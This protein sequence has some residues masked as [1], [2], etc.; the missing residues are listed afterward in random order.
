MKTRSDVVGQAK[1]R[2][3]L[4]SG[5]NE[6]M[7]KHRGIQLFGVYAYITELSPIADRQFLYQFGL[8]HS[9]EHEPIQ[10]MIGETS[11]DVWIK[12]VRIARLRCP[13]S[14]EVV[15]D[16]SRYFISQAGCFTLFSIR[17]ACKEAAPGEKTKHCKPTR[18]HGSPQ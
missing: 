5:E 7:K 1:L 2:M 3:N 10:R 16:C 14:C 6:V 18:V 4:S 8:E 13:E 9:P 17:S 12:V 15:F 11:L